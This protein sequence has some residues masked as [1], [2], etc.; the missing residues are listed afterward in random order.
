MIDIFAKVKTPKSKRLE[1]RTKQVAKLKQFLKADDTYHD[2]CAE[3]DQPVS[4]IDGIAVVFTSDLDVTAKT[5]NAKVF[6]STA[7]IDERFEIMARYLLHE[8]THCFQ[9]MEKEGK[10]TKKKS[11]VYLDRPEELEAFQNQIKFDS[12]NSPEEDVG[13][14]VSE[15]LSYHDIPKEERKERKKDLMSKVKVHKRQKKSPRTK[16]N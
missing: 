6:L 9:H 16:T 2:L 5:I 12:E 3:Y 7:L 10:K 13:R 11:D 14:Y 8:L 15:L 4:I 1:M